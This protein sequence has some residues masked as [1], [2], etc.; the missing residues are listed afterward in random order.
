MLFDISIFTDPPAIRLAGRLPSAG[1]ELWT[2]GPRRKK[3]KIQK[4][5]A[6]SATLAQKNSE[7]CRLKRPRLGRKRKDFWIVLIGAPPA[8]TEIQNSLAR[9]MANNS[10]LTALRQ[11]AAKLAESMN[12]GRHA[13]RSFSIAASHDR[14]QVSRP[15]SR[16]PRSRAVPR[17][18]ALWIRRLSIPC[19]AIN[20]R[21][22]RSGLTPIAANLR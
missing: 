17:H 1:G 6:V 19:L 7:K 11:M 16:M 18:I 20:C 9:G 5:F 22:S 3:P 12:R 13:A 10:G 2:F 21:C 15:S 4:S 8:R 14:V